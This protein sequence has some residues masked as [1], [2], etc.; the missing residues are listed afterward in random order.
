VIATG[1]PPS[2]LALKA[3]TST[4]PIVFISGDAVADGPVAS[5]ARPGGNLT[6]LSIFTAE[7]M[8]KRL[9]LLAD[10]VPGPG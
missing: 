3:A 1:N 10:L 8:P 6:G 4:I 2:A 5:L 9:E 7:L